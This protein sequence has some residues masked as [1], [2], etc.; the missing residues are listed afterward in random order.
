MESLL[1]SC[2]YKDTRCD[3]AA[4]NYYYSRKL[5]ITLIYNITNHNDLHQQL[6]VASWICN[7]VGQFPR[8]VMDLHKTTIQNLYTIMIVLYL[9]INHNNYFVHVYRVK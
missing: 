3:H 4:Y 5:I 8:Q 7:F 6:R 9:E 1:V 2:S